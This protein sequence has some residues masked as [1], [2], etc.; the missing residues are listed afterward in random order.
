M[1]IRDRAPY[2]FV[3]SPDPVTLPSRL[4]GD[5][6]LRGKVVRI[7]KLSIVVRPDASPLGMAQGPT[8]YTGVQVAW[9]SL[10]LFQPVEASGFPPHLV[11]DHTA[12]RPALDA[13]TVGGA[14]PQLDRLCGM[15]SLRVVARDWS[16]S[17][18]RSLRLV[19]ETLG[20]R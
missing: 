9:F 18:D 10:R 1:C 19:S 2:P 7:A 3:Q 5:T 6:V 17:V 20:F 8:Q 11:S 14:W 16:S 12:D 13:Q 4:E 15:L